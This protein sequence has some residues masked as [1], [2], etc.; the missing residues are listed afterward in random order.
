MVQT[1]AVINELKLTNRENKQTRSFIFA[2]LDKIQQTLIRVI[3]KNKN[4]EE[5][6]KII[7]NG[8]KK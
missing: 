1:R 5:K 4:P 2:K 7:K 8:K 6:Q 3:R